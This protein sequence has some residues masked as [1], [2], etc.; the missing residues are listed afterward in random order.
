MDSL[1]NRPNTIHAQQTKFQV[2]YSQA[3]SLFLR[4]A[5]S[6]LTRADP[7]FQLQ[8]DPRAV[9]QKVPRARLYMGELPTCSPGVLLLP[10][11]AERWL[12]RFAC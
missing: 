4:L 6:S 9:Y 11:S 2:S 7:L 10:A 1:V 8:A 5:R 12:A 3:L